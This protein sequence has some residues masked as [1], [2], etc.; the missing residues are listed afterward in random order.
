M[1]FRQLSEESTRRTTE[2]E[3]THHLLLHGACHF[4]AS[5]SKRVET[6]TGDREE[7]TWGIVATQFWV[8]GPP[9]I[10]IT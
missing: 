3:R 5:L 6:F 7:F 10:G 1:Q 9:A 8:L 2:I 4:T